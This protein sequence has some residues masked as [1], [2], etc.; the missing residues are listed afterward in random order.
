MK[1]DKEN[2]IDRIYREELSRLHATPS[3]G[4]WDKI[5][6]AIPPPPEPRTS[7]SRSVP[8][9][10]ALLFLGAWV[11][12]SLMKR[13]SLGAFPIPVAAP[14]PANASA[15]PAA[16]GYPGISYE[17]HVEWL[18]PL[19]NS[20]GEQLGLKQPSW[21]GD[22]R[23]GLV[24][25]L[26]FSEH[27]GMRAGLGIR[28]MAL[29]LR[30]RER[31]E[32]A[33]G[34]FADGLNISH[35]TY[36]TSAGLETTSEI[37][38]RRG[39]SSGPPPAPGEPFMFSLEME[40]R[41]GYYTVPAEALYYLG[42]NGMQLAFRGG[43]ALNGRLWETNRIAEA[44]FS[45]PG[46]VHRGTGLN[47]AGLPRHFLEVTAGA[48]IYYQHRSGLTARLEPGLRYALTPVFNQSSLQG[49]LLAGIGYHF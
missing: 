1:K 19:S 48:G 30:R 15:P 38:Y 47:L 32:Y 43:L 26:R 20:P 16:A 46:F 22:R 34:Y 4:F 33:P 37:G 45:G 12:F 10:L 17:W 18:V 44:S 40:Q 41:I 9:I 3:P 42:A 7:V 31:M 8:A 23:M 49:G 6:R 5:E 11:C 2:I 24:L 28:E 39:Q 35:Y 13:T 27:W 29:Q 14:L 25:D 36:Q 21:S